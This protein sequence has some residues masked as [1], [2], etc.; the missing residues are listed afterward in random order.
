LS[1]TARTPETLDFEIDDNTAVVLMTHNYV[2]DLK[3]LIALASYEV[4][5]IGI[6]GAV[7]RREELFQELIHFVPEV[8]ERFLETIHS[9]AGLHLG[10][11][12]PEEI[13]LS[14]LAEIL[15]TFRGTETIKLRELSKK[16]LK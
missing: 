15:A 7:K 10:S 12:T 2:Q 3:F 6:L 13:G 16:V 11:I 8:S 5:Y 14:I 4:N 9:P 1:A